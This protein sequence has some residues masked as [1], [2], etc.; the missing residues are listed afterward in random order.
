MMRDELTAVVTNAIL[1]LIRIK[2]D[3]LAE[4]GAKLG[5][6]PEKFCLSRHIFDVQFTTQRFAALPEGN[7]LNRITW[8]RYFFM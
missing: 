2:V 3:S 6:G 7:L 4:W 8:D 5:R 1:S